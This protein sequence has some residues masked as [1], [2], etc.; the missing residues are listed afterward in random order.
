M[1]KKTSRGYYTLPALANRSGIFHAISGRH[2][3]NLGYD[4]DF[5]QNDRII[6]FL[7][8]LDKKEVDLV[9]PEQIHGNRLKVVT[10][11]DGGKVIPGIDGLVTREKELLIGIKTSDC[12]PLLFYDPIRQLVGAVH[13]G[14]RGV[15]RGIPAKAVDLFIKLGSLPQ[16]IIVG[17]G[18]A[19]GACCYNVSEERTRAFI[20]KF[21]R[22][23]GMMSKKGDQ[24][25][26][27]IAAPAIHLLRSSG[28][29][30]ENIFSSDSCTGCRPDQYFSQRGNKPEEYGSMLT[31]IGLIR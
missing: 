25:Y 20:S 26:L 28:I 12:L 21:G 2:F 22:L 7:E 15:Y 18:P 13:A 3:G 8:A 27:N 9:V 24:G 4:L 16:N 10:R 17:I 30:P 19:I 6:K 14:W 23:P 1:L 5:T 11:S 29:M 31:V